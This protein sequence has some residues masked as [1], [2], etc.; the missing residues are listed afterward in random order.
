MGSIAADMNDNILVG[1]SESSSTMYPS[2]VV[3][4]KTKYPSERHPPG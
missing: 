4:G 3:A 2:I 1:Y